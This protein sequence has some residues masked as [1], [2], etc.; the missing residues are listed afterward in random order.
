VLRIFGQ[1]RLE[2]FNG[3]IVIGRAEIEHG[4][5]VLFLESHGGSGLTLRIL[6]E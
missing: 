5:V 4:V 6:P 1:Y 3:A 2:L